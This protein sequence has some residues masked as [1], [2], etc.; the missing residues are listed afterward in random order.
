MRLSEFSLFI[1]D[2][3][4]TLTTD[5]SSWEHVHDRLRIDNHNNFNL[6]KKGFI[7]YR[8]FFIS[9][10]KAWL[11]RYPRIRKKDVESILSEIRLRPGLKDLIQLLDD[12]GIIKVIVSGGISWLADRIIAEAYFDDNY[13]NSIYTDDRGVI[14]PDGNVMVDP[15]HKDMIVRMIQKKYGISKNQ[16]VSVGDEYENGTIHRCSAVS[17][18]IKNHHYG[19]QRGDIFINGENLY[20]IAESIESYKQ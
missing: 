3:D 13:S 7:S 1:F 5:P 2:M 14:V 4:G 17:V 12:E 16:T 18:V 19:T 15:M 9:D 8:D 10:I 20:E 11:S 6:Y